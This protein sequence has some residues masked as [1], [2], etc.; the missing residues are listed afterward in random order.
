V[1][2]EHKTASSADKAA[3]A[4]TGQSPNG[5]EF[6]D[7]AG[8][9]ATHGKDGGRVAITTAELEAL[10]KKADERDEYLSLAQRTQAEFQNYQKRIQREREQERQYHTSGMIRELLPVLDNLERALAEAKRV[11][12]TGPLVK[13]VD[14][15]L[16]H[17]LDLLERQ[18]VTRIAALGQPFDHNLH[19]ALT[20]QP[21]A[22]YPADIVAHVHEAGYRMKDRILR[23]AKVVV[24][25]GPG[26]ESSS[27]QG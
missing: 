22:E 7:K 12:E 20:S 25:T 21:S 18:G 5:A 17:F 16:R 15:V 19:E 6:P 3:G 1:S 4:A 23:P 11:G 14:L 24:S 2:Q 10:R 13:G 8:T 27:K 26:D 9:G